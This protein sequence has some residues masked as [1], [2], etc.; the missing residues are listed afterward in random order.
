MVSLHLSVPPTMQSDWHLLVPRALMAIVIR[1]EPSCQ[2]CQFQ[3]CQFQFCQF[4]GAS[5]QWC[6]RKCQ[7]IFYK[8]LL[9][10]IH[11]ALMVLQ[12]WTMNLLT[13]LQ[14][15]PSCNEALPTTTGPGWPTLTRDSINLDTYT[16]VNSCRFSWIW[17]VPEES[18]G[19]STHPPL[20]V[21]DGLEYLA[22]AFQ[23][24]N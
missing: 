12:I 7:N 13:S 5:D 4:S 16:L 23:T 11:L 24:L 2:W 8:S 10:Q 22:G 6:R 21:R 18:L 20:R 1:P 14:F 17:D 9:S 3:L 15:Q 19:A